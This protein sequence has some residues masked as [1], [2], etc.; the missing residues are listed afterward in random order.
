MWQVAERGYLSKGSSAQ[1]NPPS[2]TLLT[3]GTKRAQE[4]TTT[5]KS[6]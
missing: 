3:L 6:A 4:V 1:L 2:P 5:T